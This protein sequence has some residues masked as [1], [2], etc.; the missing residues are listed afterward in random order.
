MSKQFPSYLKLISETPPPARRADEDLAA[1]AG[2]REAFHRATGFEFE[3]VEADA[4]CQPNLLWSAPVN[5][6]VGVPPG[7]LRLMGSREGAVS[8]DAHER[9]A[10][11]DAKHLATAIGEL[12]QELLLTR[13]ALWEREA[14]LAVNVPVVEHREEARQLALRLE[15]VLHG[16][17]DAVGCH[18]AALYLLD[19]A[20]SELKLRASWGLPRRRLV[21]PARPLRD[22]LADLEAMLG[23]AVVLDDP[24]MFNL[25]HVPEACAACVCV[26][27]STPTMPLGTLWIFSQ[28]PREFSDDD[29]NMIEIAAGRIAADLEREMLM[30]EAVRH[31]RETASAA[32]VASPPKAIGEE[33]PIEPSI[34]IKQ[35][36]LPNVAPL[37]E[38]WQLAASISPKNATGAAFYDWFNRPDGSLAIV[39]GC[40]A[41]NGHRPAFAATELRA[42]ARVLGPDGRPANQFVERAAGLLWA[43]SAGDLSASLLQAVVSPNQPIMELAIGGP[44]Q[45]LKVL[46]NRYEL[47]ATPTRPLGTHEGTRVKL[48][49]HTMAR[50][51]L[52][53]G[54]ALTRALSDQ[55]GWLSEIN[56]AL[57]QSLAPLVKSPVE[58]LLQTAQET[59]SQ[60]LDVKR[61]CERAVI[62]IKRK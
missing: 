41:G 22:Q 34:R 38:G 52:V 33:R 44:L 23:H 10:L 37:I 46:P 5:P 61:Q 11:T 18:A 53:V 16:A 35:E 49:K 40:V 30:A 4:P 20:T 26:P 50:N 29:T 59:L 1:L 47:L 24:Q 21:Q 39:T 13:E 51:D 12:W 15:A 36:W 42:A 48:Q 62:V 27:I 8:E 45:A 6:G 28:E 58:R 56:D 55:G 31:K 7:L 17:A 43:H 14:E 19:D 2:V 9:V 54:Y 60:I 3:Y 57:A 32:E 25:W